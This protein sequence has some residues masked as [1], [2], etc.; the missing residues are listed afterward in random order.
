MSRTRK[1][2]PIEVRA[3]REAKGV[4]LN[5]THPW[6]SG[7]HSRAANVEA[8]FYAHE[9]RE[10]E[11]FIAKA[12]EFGWTVETR[13]ITG[14]LYTEA[15]QDRAYRHQHA[16]YY[17][18][19]VTQQ[20]ILRDLTTRH[21]KLTDRPQARGRFIIWPESDVL[22][23]QYAEA[24]R[25]SAKGESVEVEVDLTSLPFLERIRHPRYLYDYDDMLTSSRMSK[26]P[27]I[28]I[29]V[30][31]T[32]VFESAAR[33]VWWDIYEYPLDSTKPCSCCRDTRETDK[34]GNTDTAIRNKTSKITE[35][36]NNGDYD[37]AADLADA[38]S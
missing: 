30:T 12:K 20:S 4:K 35:A 24:A 36:F 10:L 6:R 34:I 26:N 11:E 1:D 19:R 21:R 28:F 22:T 7:V 23:E 33:E 8:L 18:S 38:I 27:N 17:P 3:R 15:N 9:V 25:K 32:K 5:N 29:A 31:A 16:H 13:E 14:H 37:R 2:T